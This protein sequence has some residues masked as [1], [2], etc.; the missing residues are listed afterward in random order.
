MDARDTWLAAVQRF[1][2]HRAFQCRLIIDG[3]ST[4][5]EALDVRIANGPFHGG[6]ELSMKPTQA[7]GRWLFGSF[8][9]ASKWTL[10]RVWAGLLVG[11]ADA[12]CIQ[13]VAVRQAKVETTPPRF[14]SVDGE[15]MTRTPIQI[16]VAPKALHLIVP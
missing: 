1:A 14:V 8:Q 6:V 16:S 12:T 9:G 13:T 7:V 10:G 4:E 3:E 11:L 15:I 5:W 2:V